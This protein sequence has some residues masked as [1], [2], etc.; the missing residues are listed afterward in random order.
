MFVWIDTWTPSNKIA[1]IAETYEQ[2]YD[3]ATYAIK[4]ARKEG[5]LQDLE[6]SMRWD[7]EQYEYQGTKTV[8]L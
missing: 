5:K 8:V 2:A 3:D 6:R 7:L 1:V 4:E